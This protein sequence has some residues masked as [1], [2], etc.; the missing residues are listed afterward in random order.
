MFNE[1]GTGSVEY[2]VGRTT[3]HFG[4]PEGT[5]YED[6]GTPTV[7]RKATVKDWVNAHSS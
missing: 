6:E 5:T 4:S 2:T 3:V 7:S 1:L